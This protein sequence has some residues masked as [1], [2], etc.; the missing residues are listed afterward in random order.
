MTISNIK[1]LIH[2]IYQNRNI[3]IT[4]QNSQT[5][6]QYKMLIGNKL[7]FSTKLLACEI[8]QYEEYEDAEANLIN[9]LLAE[10]LLSKSA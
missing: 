1:P 7:I 5:Y 9:D 10:A 6:M 2:T 4:K 8:K 3:T